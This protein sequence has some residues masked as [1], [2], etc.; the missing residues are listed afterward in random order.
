VSRIVTFRNTCGIGWPTNSTRDPVPYVFCATADRANGSAGG[1]S[2][3]VDVTG[4][5]SLEG[6]FGQ[7]FTIRDGRPRI[8]MDSHGSHWLGETCELWPEYFGADRCA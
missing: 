5:R 7:L 3:T 1:G 2:R 6:E 4:E 8:N